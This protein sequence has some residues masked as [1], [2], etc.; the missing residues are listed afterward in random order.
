VNINKVQNVTGEGHT[1]WKCRD[2]CLCIY[3]RR[4]LLT[5]TGWRYH[6]LLTI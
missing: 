6:M 1:S 5:F 3:H 2:V 4:S